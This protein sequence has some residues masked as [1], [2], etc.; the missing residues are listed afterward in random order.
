[1]AIRDNKDYIRVPLY[2]YYT[3]ITGWG[4]LLKY[5]LSGCRGSIRFC[6]HYR[7]LYNKGIA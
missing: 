5:A 4:V 7:G 1:M 6:R 2:S 3:T